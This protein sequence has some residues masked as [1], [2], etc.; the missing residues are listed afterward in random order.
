MI[1][2]R[3]QDLWSAVA[4]VWLQPSTSELL[5]PSFVPDRNSLRVVKN[6]EPNFSSVQLNK[7]CLE[8]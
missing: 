1:Q 4:I 6:S 3:T 8:P 2:L 7:T 5:M